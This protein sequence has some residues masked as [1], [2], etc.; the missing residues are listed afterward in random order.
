MNSEKD[1]AILDLLR[2]REAEFVRIWSCEQEISRI[3][4]MSNFPFDVP[5][6]LPCQHRIRKKPSNRSVEKTPVSPPLLRPLES[7]AENAYHV[8]YRR[9]GL[10]EDSFLTDSSVIST[11]L[12][13]TTP[14]FAIL[15]VETVL[16]H[17][18][19]E[20]QSVE[21]LWENSSKTI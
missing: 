21:R 5:T 12:T 17:S 20:W 15:L 9:D 13:L 7:P 1:I 3:L 4:G 14:G 18:P 16:F 19:D 6:N 10:E 2:L 8:V 11:L